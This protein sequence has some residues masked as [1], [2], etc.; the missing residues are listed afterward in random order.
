LHKHR[1]LFKEKN[2]LFYCIALVFSQFGDRL[3]QIVLIGFV[4]K[5]SPGSTLQLAKLLTF[6]IIPAFFISPIAGVYVDRWNKK[7]V[8]FMADMLRGIL[9]LFV[10]FFLINSTS[11]APLYAALFLIFASACFFLPAKFSVIPDLVASDKLLLANSVVFITG[12]VAGVAGFTLG[13]LMVE[14]LDLKWSVFINSLVYFLSATSILFVFYKRKESYQKESIATL[15]RQLTSILRKSFLHELKEGFKYLLSGKSVRFV[16]YVFFTLMSAMGAVYVVL[17]VFIQ[18]TLGSVTKDV[19]LFGL[20][21]CIG[22]LLGSVI[23]GRIGQK[24]SRN[25]PI[26]ASLLTSG[27]FMALFAIV[28]KTT[29]SF[30]AG[31]AVMFLIGITI[32]PIIISANTIIHESIDERMRGRIFSSIGIIM[33]LSLLLFMFTASTLAEFIDR[34]WI[35]IA[36]GI[37]FAGCGVLGF[38]LKR[39]TTS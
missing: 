17:V 29:G 9:V 1:D 28:L 34:M 37:L 25:K 2:F 19:G 15:S 23:Y 36:T 20:V 22:L 33:N 38:I 11:V 16:I 26:F 8:M 7:S 18:E 31:A 30:F 10:A 4:H 39:E 32:S 12:I 27:I 14:W 35:L 13:G 24:F 6:T 5:I 21:L 3:V